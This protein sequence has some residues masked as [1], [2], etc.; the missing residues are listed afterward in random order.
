M[1]FVATNILVTVRAC[2]ATV[3]VAGCSTFGLCFWTDLRGV[4]A[5]PQVVRRNHI[6]TINRIHVCT[7]PETIRGT[8][9]KTAWT[10]GHGFFGATH[11]AIVVATIVKVFVETMPSNLG[12]LLRTLIRVALVEKVLRIVKAL[13][14]E[15]IYFNYPTV[16]LVTS[17]KFGRLTDFFVLLATGIPVFVGAL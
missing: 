13:A 15:I 12:L 5:L 7:N 9:V 10:T 3:L 17:V 2:Q 6:P 8:G 4:A 1:V 14:N 16:L 11:P